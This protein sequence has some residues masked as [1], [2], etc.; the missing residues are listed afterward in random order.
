[1]IN[2]VLLIIIAEK[3]QINQ[4][5]KKINLDRLLQ[6]D[7]LEHAAIIKA[8]PCYHFYGVGIENDLVTLTIGTNSNKDYKSKSVYSIGPMVSILAIAGGIIASVTKRG[9][10]S[11]F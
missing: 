1:V 4:L 10:T 8:E 5:F 7:T 6:Q 3:E 11:R 9:G 2:Y